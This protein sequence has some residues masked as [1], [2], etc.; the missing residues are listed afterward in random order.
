MAKTLR[1][2]L[3]SG[4]FSLALSSG[5]FGFFAHAGLVAALDEAGLAPASLSGSS[6][7]AL[8]AGAWASGRSGEELAEHLMA[9]R[10]ADFWDPAPGAGLLRGELF[11]RRL[12]HTLGAATFEACRVPLAVSVFDLATRETR[13]IDR[14]PLASAVRASCTFPGLFQPTWHEGRRYLDGG[15][16]DRPGLLGAKP[17]RVL[18]H[19][20]A[21]RSPWRRRGSA[22]LAIPP[23]AEMIA[24]VL[25]D[26]PR[27]GPFRLEDGLRA[28]TLARAR[29]R[30]VLDLPVAP[31]LTIA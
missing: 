19:H 18:F 23:R 2:H 30:R 28:Y 7:G 5:F 22:S 27:L 3:A 31:V 11:Q 4:P 13:V 1:E 24:V 16:A 12:E 8:V 20:L 25:G 9:L 17:G 6:A 10:R 21:S 29:A 14:G 26:L 15:I